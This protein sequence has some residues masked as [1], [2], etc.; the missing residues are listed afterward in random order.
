MDARL[1]QS[2]IGSIGGDILSKNQVSI[3]S[4]HIQR[5]ARASS[6]CRTRRPPAS[7]STTE[8][9]VE[10]HDFSFLDSVTE[11][12]E[13]VVGNCYRIDIAEY[14]GKVTAVKIYE[15][16]DAKEQIEADIALNSRIRHHAIVKYIHSCTTA[17]PPFAVF[18]SVVP[19]S[20][21]RDQA[22]ADLNS[23]PCYLAGTLRRGE[24][25]SLVAGVR[26]MHDAASGLDHI[27]KFFPLAGI[28]LDL[29]IKK[30]KI[31]ISL[32]VGEPDQAQDG[33]LAVYHKLCHE[34]FREAN[35]ECHFDRRKVVNNPE[36]SETRFDSE[37]DPDSNSDSKSLPGY[38]EV[39]EEESKPT[40]P[41]QEYAFV[42]VDNLSLRE[43]SADCSSFINQLDVSVQY[44]HYLQRNS[45]HATPVR[46][47]CSGYIRQEVTLS[48]SVS[49]SAIISHRTPSLQ[50]ISDDGV[51]LT[52]QCCRCLMWGHR[53]CQSGTMCQSCSGT[54]K[55]AAEKSGVTALNRYLSDA[56]DDKTGIVTEQVEDDDWDFT[57][58]ADGEDR[59][60]AKGTSLFAR[61]VVD[62]Y[63]LAIFR[64][65][66]T[67]SRANNETPATPR[68]VSNVSVLSDVESPSPHRRGRNPS[69]TFRKKPRQFLRPKSPPSTYPSKTS[70]KS[71]GAPPSLPAA[72]SSSTSGGLMAMGKRAFSP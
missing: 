61:G 55:T 63:K 43:I 71:S 42:Q 70:V 38:I 24:K 54:S 11:S 12:P 18:D 15:G 51:T 50:E 41:R 32:S 52:V 1:E 8:L 39:V 35:R 2:I 72:S 27:S 44:L 68:T 48:T 19:G 4:I 29:F 16:P 23:L 33:H 14:Q 49:D 13:L 62:R 36:D 37:S 69:L 20:E 25:D 9:T 3:G 10:N 56:I 59:N 6:S 30:D 57:E 64:K 66:S 22:S 17:S 21:S 7:R 46:H 53:R 60:G 67:P 45:L 58:A 31:C 65:A 34:A 26:L 47:R 40:L 5:K 28:A